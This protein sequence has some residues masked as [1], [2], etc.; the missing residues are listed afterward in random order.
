MDAIFSECRTSLDEGLVTEIWYVWWESG[1]PCHTKKS[2]GAGV[3]SDF[4]SWKDRKRS[5]VAGIHVRSVIFDAVKGTVSLADIECLTI[6][7]GN[8]RS[9]CDHE[10]DCANSVHRD[11]EWWNQSR[12]R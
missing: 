8:K 5:L 4:E 10:T 11:H 12:R 7:D 6:W 3:L 2:D 1:S 9:D